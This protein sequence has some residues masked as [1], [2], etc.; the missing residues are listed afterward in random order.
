M[1]FYG[2]SP[3]SS[4]KKSTVLLE[5]EVAPAQPPSPIPRVPRVP[6]TW[7]GPCWKTWRG[8]WPLHSSW[9][10]SRLKGLKEKNGGDFTHEK[11]SSQQT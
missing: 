5:G 7:S 4:G 3:V 2:I 10:A 6:R 8:P 9:L 1:I 11:L